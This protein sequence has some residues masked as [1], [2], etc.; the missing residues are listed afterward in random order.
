MPAGIPGIRLPTLFGK[1]RASE[2][3]PNVRF[4]NRALESSSYFSL[5]KS[6]RAEQAL[7]LGTVDGNNH[8][9]IPVA[10]GLDSPRNSLGALSLGFLGRG[11]I[12]ARCGR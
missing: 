10:G 9:T 2:F 1:P 6:S 5:A 3:H 11:D 8:P 12:A 4:F 7:S